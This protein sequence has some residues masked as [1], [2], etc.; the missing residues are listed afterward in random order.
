M[1]GIKNPISVDERVNDIKVY[2]TNSRSIKN[3]I[4]LLRGLANVKK[5]YVISI[6]KAWLDSADKEFETKFGISGYNVN[7]TLL[8]SKIIYNKREIMHL[9]SSK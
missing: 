5:C 4:G 6:T 9:L 2:N 8:C 1:T 7:H 3:K